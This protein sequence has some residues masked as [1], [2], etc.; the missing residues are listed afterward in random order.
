MTKI[1][2]ENKKIIIAGLVSYK[3]R[4]SEN[5]FSELENHIKNNGGEIVGQLIQRR[6]VSG[7]QISGGSKKLDQPLDSSTYISKGKARELSEL[8][9]KTK[10]D[11]VIFINKLSKS[12]IVSSSDKLGQ[13]TDCEILSLP[14]FSLTTN[15][16]TDK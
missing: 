8:C 13:L 14:E 11:V 7:S 4:E 15:P 3:M 1:N 10:S 16:M 5:L 12:Q 2:I 9:S 6:G